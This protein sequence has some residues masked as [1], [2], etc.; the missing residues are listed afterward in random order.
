[1]NISINDMIIF[2]GTPD[3][4]KGF[5][6]AYKNHMEGRETLSEGKPIIVRYIKEEKQYLVLDGYHRLVKGLLEGNTNF[7]CCYDWFA[8]EDFWVPPKEH[9]FYLKDYV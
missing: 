5:A 9:R 2:K 7:D 1:M 4:E 6:A 3:F 8:K